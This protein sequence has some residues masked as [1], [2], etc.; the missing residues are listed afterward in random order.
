MTQFANNA[1]DAL[2]DLQIHKVKQDI[3]L[4]LSAGDALAEVSIFST[5]PT[6]LDA[7]RARWSLYRA[8][9]DASLD[10]LHATTP[11]H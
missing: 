3:N 10:A 5:T 6:E 1:A 7:R 8:R 11:Q 2:N 4:L 9:L